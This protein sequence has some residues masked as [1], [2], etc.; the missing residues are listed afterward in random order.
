MRCFCVHAISAEPNPA[1][2]MMLC[3]A[4]IGRKVFGFVVVYVISVHIFCVFSSEGLR[5][6]VRDYYTAIACCQLLFFWGQRFSRAA[7][8][9]FRLASVFR[10]VFFP[11]A[12]WPS[13]WAIGFAPGVNRGFVVIA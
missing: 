6:D 1:L 9:L 8:M 7:A 4:L 2:V 12:I 10:A 3:I 13:A 5:S 11:A